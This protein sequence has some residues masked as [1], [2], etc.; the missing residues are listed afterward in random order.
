M[1]AQL[2][3][4]IAPTIIQ[5]GTKD[6][7]LAKN[8]MA[9]INFR[10]K[11]DE[12]IEMVKSHVKKVINDDRVIITPYGNM[13]SNP[14]PESSISSVGYKLVT[15]TI[16]ELFPDSLIVPYIVSG[17]TDAR[18]FYDLSDSVYRF[19]PLKI[20]TADTARIHG[21]NERIGVDNYKDLVQFYGR[22]I[23]RSQGNQ[24]KTEKDEL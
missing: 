21:V 22:L 15:E 17:G 8:A 6:N 20:I 16:T 23:L 4:T 1:N 7:I 3:T 14:S 24:V 12:S 11:T 5:A 9:I 13:L 2:R 19:V 10:I 18:Y